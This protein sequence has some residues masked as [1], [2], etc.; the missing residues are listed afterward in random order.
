MQI[1]PNTSVTYKVINVFIRKYGHLVRESTQQNVA[2]LGS[3]PDIRIDPTEK[4]R[5]NSFSACVF[6]YL[7]FQYEIAFLLLQFFFLVASYFHSSTYFIPIKELFFSLFYQ[8]NYLQFFAIFFIFIIPMSFHFINSI[9]L[10]Y[11]FISLLFLIKIALY[12]YLV[13]LCT[14]L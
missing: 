13:F 2:E 7:K 1:R 8:F 14:I 3:I 6:Q 11:V 9:I 4:R 5:V 10:C 12:I